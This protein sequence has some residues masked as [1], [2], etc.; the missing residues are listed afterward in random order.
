[1]TSPS[2]HRIIS[3]LLVGWPTRSKPARIT[4]PWRSR[5]LW[6]VGKLS[7]RPVTLF[8]ITRTPGRNQFSFEITTRGHLSEF[9][10]LLAPSMSFWMFIFLWPTIFFSNTFVVEGEVKRVMVWTRGWELFTLSVSFQLLPSK[11]SVRIS[12][13]LS[14]NYKAL[15][16]CHWDNLRIFQTNLGS[17]KFSHTRIH[18]Y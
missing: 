10:V 1:M 3:I 11:C 6:S 12:Q 8:S 5:R 13:M 17:I 14:W 7:L 9:S 16:S 2:T 15:N 18:T 4:I